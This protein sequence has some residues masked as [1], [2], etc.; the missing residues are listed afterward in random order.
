MADLGLYEGNR[1][2]FLWLGSWY[3]PFSY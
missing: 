1:H 2:V 3:F